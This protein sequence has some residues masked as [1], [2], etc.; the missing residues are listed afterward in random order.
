MTIFTLVMLGCIGAGALVALVALFARW[1]RTNR[2][3]FAPLG[4]LALLVIE[5][6]LYADFT[7]LPRGLFHPGSGATQLRLPEIYITLALLGR[8][9]ARG[10]PTRIGLSAALWLAFGVWMVVGAVEGHL[11]HNP[12]S[13]NLYE[14]KAIVYVVGGYALAA[15]VPVRRY[16]DTRAFYWLRNLCVGAATLVDLMTIGHVTVSVHIPLLPLQGFGPVG[17]DTALL[18]VTIGVIYFLR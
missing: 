15:G 11:Y 8:L 1:E 7:N 17:S 4:L 12:L 10:K 3:H 9:F 18:Y 13:Q 16:L 2:Q 6:T 14:A 5:A